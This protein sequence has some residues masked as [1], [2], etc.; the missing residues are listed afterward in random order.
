VRR[1]LVVGSI[2]FLGLAGGARPATAQ[3]WVSSAGQGSVTFVTQM[4]DHVG[5]LVDDGTRIA[6]CGTTNV[7]LDVEVD[8]SL[9][10]R[11]S[12]SAGLP[13]IFAKYRGEAP[14]TVA[15][16]L[17]YLAVDA[18]HCVH[19]T[20][21]D[22]GFTAH[23]NLVNVHRAFMLTPSVSLGVPSH[24]YDHVGEAVVGFG[25][26]ELGIGADVGQRLDAILPGL[27]VEGRYTYTL[28]P[29]VLDIPH[30]R[31]NAVVQGGFAFT[32]HLSGH[33]ILSWQRTHGGLRFPAD[34]Q[35]F[36]ER[37][38]EFHRLL[39]DNYLQAGGAASY[40]WHQW[41]V[42][43]SFLRAVRGT[44]SHD[45]HVYSVNLGWSFEAGR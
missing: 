39:Q 6:C 14:D 25:L 8:Y 28:V 41:D 4:I 30:N 32:R 9:T 23:Y 42:S 34:V 12:I 37:Y 44:N 7:A 29:R 3:A 26:K 40:S 13:Y 22:V 17:P 19:S 21:Q 10:D 24:A 1:A 36:P 20:F 33:A 16:F 18:C 27:S 15:A 35:P 38:S 45:V 2:A 43:A 31:S 11:W 5:R